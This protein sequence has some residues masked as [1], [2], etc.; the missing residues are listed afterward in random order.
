GEAMEIVKLLLV[1]FLAAYLEEYR[2]LLAMAGRRVGRVHLPPLPYLAPILV[3]IG[4][5]LLLFWLQKDLGPALLFSTVLL[6]MLYV[7]SGRAS[8]VV[9]GLG[10]LI[11]GGALADRVF[12]HVPTRVISWRDPWSNRES[13]GYPLVQALFSLAYG[14]VLG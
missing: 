4:V 13:I 11:L 3:M 7:A 14:A 12:S 2:E 9:L 5:A 8:Y 6:A 1:V 10:L